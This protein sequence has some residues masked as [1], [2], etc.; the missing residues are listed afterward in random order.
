MPHSLP[1]T[2][3]RLLSFVH[4]CLPVLAFVLACDPSSEQYEP[5]PNVFCLLRPD[6]NVA[7]VLCG[8]TTGYLDTIA[9]PARWNGVS[10]A[11]VRISHAGLD[12]VCAAVADSLGLYTSESLPV[13]AQDTYALSIRYP[14]GEQ[15][16]G[17]TIVPDTFSITA[18]DIDTFRHETEPGVYF[19]EYDVTFR[20]TR[21]IGVADYLVQVDAWYVGQNDSILL[22]DG[23]YVP[24]AGEASAWLQRFA[25]KD[26]GTEDTLFLNRARLLVWAADRNYA[27]YVKSRGQTL[28]GSHERWHLNGGVGVFGSACI[29]ETTLRFSVSR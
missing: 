19:V 8:L 13:R 12:Y 21:A 22:R 25:L 23:P 17:S 2:R 18:I 11:E 24:Y 4:R 20:W 7:R 28:T 6:R 16:N 9:D 15:V 27:D 29:A 14:T 5:E 10:G 26:D 1:I 3:R